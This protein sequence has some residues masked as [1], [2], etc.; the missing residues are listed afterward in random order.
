MGTSV[1]FCAQAYVK[2]AFAVKPPDNR[3][4]EPR[5]RVAV[6]VTD[7]AR[8]LL[9]AHR[10]PRGRR[11]LLPGGGVE[12]GETLVAA[13]RREL[14]EETGVVAEIGPLVIVCEAIGPARHVVN[15]VFAMAPG[16]AA[17][18]RAPAAERPSDPAIVATRWVT[19]AEL[20]GVALHPPIAAQLVA[21]WSRGFRGPVQFL[22]NV[23]VPED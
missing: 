12:Q 13:A 7:G 22:G 15:L 6:C 18:T 3:G 17:T 11:W 8:L 1:P 2:Q 10:R 21:A 20:G 5:I 14:L 9:V 16:S 23:W 4:M 19:R